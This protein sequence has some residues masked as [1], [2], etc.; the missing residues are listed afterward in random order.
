MSIL[1]VKN[2]Y[3]SFPIYGGIFHKQVGAVQAVNDVSFSLEKGETIGVVGESGCGKTTLGRTLVRLYEPTSGTVLV[4]GKDFRSYHGDDLKHARRDFQMIFQDPYASLNPRMSVRAI[5]EEPLKLHGIGNAE[6]RLKSVLKIAE[7]VGLRRD[8][9]AR[10][11]H[12]FSGGQRQRIGIARSLI[13][14]PK[15]VIADEPVSA[16]DVSIQ[17]QVLNLLN[18]LKKEF[19]LSYIFI[20]H[21][22]AV[23][24]FISDKIMIMYLGR[25]MEV[26]Y[27]DD[28]FA[29]PQHPY[30]KALL[31]SIP[32]PNPHLRGK[33]QVL[34]GDVPSPSR[35]PSGCVFHT[36]CP[37]AT[38]RCKTE[39]PKLHTVNPNK[40]HQVAC[41]F[42]P[43][44]G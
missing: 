14:N 6:E 42:V 22:L 23:V 7:I 16:L 37:L 10:Y 29:A 13:L 19:G 11:P 20:T 1:E 24:K 40:Q 36:R 38:D 35:P 18:D 44:Q 43:G 41:H 5:L 30:T 33:G 9:L 32:K 27:T 25:M 4:N 17:S 26:G 21:D 34:Q 15:I 12:E 31:S 3:K 39:I 8:A 28:I 2:L